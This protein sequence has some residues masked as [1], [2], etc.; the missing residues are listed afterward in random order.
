[1]CIRREVSMGRGITAKEI[2]KKLNVSATAVSMALNNRPGVSTDTR[3]RII[4]EAEKSGYDFTRL[5]LKKNKGGDVYCIIYRAHNAILNYAPIFSELTDGMEQE[6]RKKGYR[7][8]TLQIYEKTDDVQKCIEDL[9]V[10]GCTG[11]ILLGTEITAAV[12]KQF[13]QLSLPVV[14][15]DAYFDSVSCSSVVINNTQ[16]AYLATSY[17]ISRY[18]RQP[19]HLCSSY[20]IENFIER[21]YGFH[22]A[23]RENGMSI[24]KS[25]THELSPSIE[26]AFSDMLEIIDRGD[27]LAGSY[28]ADNDLIAIGAIKALKLR[29][30]NIPDDIAIIGFDN[31]PE[32]RIVEPSLTTIEIP[33][34][35]MGQTA[36]AQLINQLENP[37][38][39]PVKTE[40]S[41]GIVKRFSA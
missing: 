26:G 23:V 7:L 38:L 6:C 30:Y 25:I 13:Q 19:G 35:F 18:G 21:N 28:F 15:L 3:K 39:H 4:D 10:S 24:G 9:S 40:I 37:V 8:K 32:S 33:R 17:L 27:A 2:A 36:A 29:A 22:R 31:I 12:C 14:L 11:I 41:T 16:G 5:A 20:V 34:R 1:M